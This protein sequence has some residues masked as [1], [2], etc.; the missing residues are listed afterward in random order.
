[1]TKGK[2]ARNPSTRVEVLQLKQMVRSADVIATSK[3]DHYVIVRWSR[4]S[5]RFESIPVGTFHSNHSHEILEK[6]K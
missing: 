6:L 1:M 3:I 4:N 5:G 2:K